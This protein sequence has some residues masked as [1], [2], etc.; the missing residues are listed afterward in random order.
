MIYTWCAPFM[1]VCHICSESDF[2][3]FL[4]L[5]SSLAVELYKCK[6]GDFIAV[7]W[8]FEMIL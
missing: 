3:V 1:R 8:I 7:I 2:C 4:A 5:P 6:E